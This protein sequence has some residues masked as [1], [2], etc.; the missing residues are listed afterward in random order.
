MESGNN[1]LSMTRHDARKFSTDIA[2][3]IHVLYIHATTLNPS[4]EA[5][6][7]WAK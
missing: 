6:K 4:S 1:D 2:E 3:I 5:G 7:G